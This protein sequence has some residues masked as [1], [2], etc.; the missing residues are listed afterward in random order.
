MTRRR[1]ENPSAAT[2]ARR[3]SRERLSAAQLDHERL[4]VRADGYGL[5]AVDVI[6]QHYVQGGKCPACERSI[7]VHGR[8]S[9]I[10][11]DHATGDVRGLLCRD[12]NGL[13]VPWIE[14]ML[15]AGLDAHVCTERALGYVVNRGVFQRGQLRLEDIA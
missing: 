3:A 1:V 9:A 14:R 12:C 2:L 8:E 15:A 5:R 6:H 13:G 7:P 10:D 4:R 11:H